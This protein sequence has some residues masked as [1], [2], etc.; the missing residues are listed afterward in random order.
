MTDRALWPLV[1]PYPIQENAVDAAELALHEAGSSLMVLPTGLGK[2]VCFAEL[3]RRYRDEHGLRTLVVAHTEELI[4]QA[5]DKMVRFGGLSV[6]IEMAE[7]RVDIT[8]ELYPVDVVI[9]SMQSM[10]RPSRLARYPSDSFG[11]IVIDEAHRSAAVSYGKIID[12]FRGIIRDEKGEPAGVLESTH[13]LGVTATPDRRDRKALSDIFD[14]VAFVY[15]I[16]LAR[17]LPGQPNRS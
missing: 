3:A 12:H 13:L 5:A 9:T 4:D 1:T 7:R 2:T 16:L 8:N 6:G 17:R 15:G 11:L 14:S 10:S